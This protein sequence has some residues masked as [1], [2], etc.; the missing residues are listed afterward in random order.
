MLSLFED[1]GRAHPK[2]DLIGGGH[3]A[4]IVTDP[5]EACDLVLPNRVLSA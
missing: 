3:G 4:L 2:L 1:V 5:S